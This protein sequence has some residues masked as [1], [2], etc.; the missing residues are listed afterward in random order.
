MNVYEE[1]TLRLKNTFDCYG[2]VYFDDVTEAVK[3]TAR[4]M[5]EHFDNAM[6]RE[7]HEHIQSNYGSFEEH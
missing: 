6:L 1:I 2:S 7:I 4:D 5:G 3:K